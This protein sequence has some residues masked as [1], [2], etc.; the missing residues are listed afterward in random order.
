MGTWQERTL[1]FRS[2]SPVEPKVWMGAWSMSLATL[3]FLSYAGGIIL[4]Y[5]RPFF[6]PSSVLAVGG[7]IALA[8]LA[9]GSRLRKAAAGVLLS[10]MLL[11]EWV[12][13]HALIPGFFEDYTGFQYTAWVW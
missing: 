2:R 3:L 4:M 8:W 5:I 10:S 9:E 1:T 6:F 13:I 12:K 7:G 11:I